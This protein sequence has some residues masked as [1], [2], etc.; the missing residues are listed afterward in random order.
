MTRRDYIALA[1]AIRE[2]REILSYS[3]YCHLLGKVGNTLAADNDRFN[4]DRWWEACMEGY[5]RQLQGV[6]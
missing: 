2:M 3:T 5:D 6:E 4:H 1:G